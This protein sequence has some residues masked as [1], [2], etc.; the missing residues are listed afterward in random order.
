MAAARAMQQRILAGV[1]VADFCP[2]LRDLPE[3]ISRDSFHA[4]YGGLG[5][6]ATQRLVDRIEQR[7]AACEGLR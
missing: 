6:A 7:L 2:D 1:R 3:R 5:G 4:D